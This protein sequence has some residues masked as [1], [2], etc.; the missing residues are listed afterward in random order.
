[1]HLNCWSI[2]CS[3]KIACR[4]CSGYIF[5]LDLTPGFNGLGKGN[6]KTRRKTFKFWDLVPSYIRGLTARPFLHFI[7]KRYTCG[8]VALCFVAFKFSVLRKFMSCFTLILVDVSVPL[9]Q[10]QNSFRCQCFNPEEYGLEKSTT[11]W[12]GRSIPA[13][14]GGWDDS[15]NHYIPHESQVSIYHNQG[16]VDSLSVTVKIQERRWSVGCL[17]VVT[18]I[19]KWC[20]IACVVMVRALRLFAMQINACHPLRLKPYGYVQKVP[21]TGYISRSTTSMCQGFFVVWVYKHI[22]PD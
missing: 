3:W 16:S 2:K 20:L 7:K 9:E 11:S 15:R 21:N 6:C 19:R 17:T 14:N 22:N 10:L 8:F 12:C 5:I 13:T 1:M 18:Q 4:R